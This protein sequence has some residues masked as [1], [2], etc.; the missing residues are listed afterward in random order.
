MSN[1]DKL[2]KIIENVDLLMTKSK[3]T[4]DPEFQ[5]WKSK[6]E[7]LVAQI[8]G[9]D[10]IEYENL[11]T[12]IYSPSACVLGSDIS[13]EYRDGLHTA[14][15]IL[16][17][18]LDEMDVSSDD[19]SEANSEWNY[20]K[21]F[22][23]HGHD[24]ELKHAVARMIEKQD[25]L[26]AII[27]SEQIAA[28]KTIIEKIEDNSDVADAIC[29]FTADDFGRAKAD[30][31]EKPRARQ[32]VVFEAGYFMGKLGRDHVVM[33]CEDGVEI[34]GD[35]SGVVY[36]GKNHWEVEMLKALKVMGYNIDMNKLLE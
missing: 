30:T 5:A 14:K 12:I 11:S 31:E 25:N 1:Y 10:S 29:L 17:D 13:Q 28:G 18:Y 4:D 19:C 24:G 35:L 8:Y 34:P 27:L 9:A 3:L 2:K 6:A 33:I 22:I 21:V 23:V 7:R 36:T 15:L 16:Q 32:N 20:S 26:K